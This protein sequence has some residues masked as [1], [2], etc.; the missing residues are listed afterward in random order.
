MYYIRT[1]IRKKAIKR[2]KFV[3]LFQ[4]KGVL[5]KR[6]EKELDDLKIA[7]EQLSKQMDLSFAVNEKGQL[8]LYE[9]LMMIVPEDVRDIFEVKF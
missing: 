1:Y 7:L 6:G 4:S 8:D 9:V 2:T 5:Y 3:I